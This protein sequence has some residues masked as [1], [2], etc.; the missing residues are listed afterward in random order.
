MIEEL[1]ALTKEYL[2]PITVNKATRNKW[3]VDCMAESVDWEAELLTEEKD[4]GSKKS[5]QD[6][7][8]YD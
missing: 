5:R 1:L 8:P 2:T 7:M 4:D 3:L 6:N